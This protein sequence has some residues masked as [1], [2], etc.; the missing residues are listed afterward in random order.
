MNVK[1]IILMR[2][3]LRNTRGEKVRSGKLMAQ[4]AHA[5]MIWLSRRIKKAADNASKFHAFTDNSL[6]IHN[7]LRFSGPEA[8]WLLNGSFTKIVLGV[9]SEQQLQDLVLLASHA[10]LTTEIV[11]DNGQTEFGGVP[12][13]TCAAIGP[14]LA[15]YI[16]PITGDLKPY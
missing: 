12:T 13:I 6:T 16:D 4:A 9:D 2:R 5:A 14:D 3:D 10:G 7:F 8:E 1:Q 15:E 11:T